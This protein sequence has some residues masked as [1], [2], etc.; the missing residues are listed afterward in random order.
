MASAIPQLSSKLR[1]LVFCLFVVS[2]GVCCAAENSVPNSIKYSTDYNWSINPKDDLT[3]PGP[4]T[5]N[6]P[7]CP[8]G[9]M[10]NEPEYWIYVSGGGNGEA[11]KVTGGT[12]AGNAAPGT[13]QFATANSHAA[14]YTVGSASSGLQE[15]LIAAR[16]APRDFPNT[17]PSGRV[18]V[19]PGEFDA[20]AR[21]SIR[22]SNIEVDFSGSIIDCWMDDTCIF[23]GDPVHSGKYLDISVVGP[24]GRPM[25]KGGQH[26]FLEVNAMKTRVFNVSLRL[27]AKG[28]SF[29]SYVQVDDDQ[30][31]L[32][33]GLDTSLGQTYGTDG[34]LCNATICNPAVYAPGGKTWAVG[35]LKHLNMSLGCDSNG[36]DWESG[37]SLRVSDS[38]IQGYPQYA[39]RAG[40][41]HGGYQGLVTENVYGEIGNCH[42]PAG[43]IGEAGIIAQGGPVVIHGSLVL[44][45]AS[46]LF[47]DTGKTEYRYYI[48]ARSATFGS[49]NLLY[50][51]KARTNGSGSITVTTPDI[52]GATSFDLLRVN[53][54]AAGDP[55]LQTPNGTGNYAVARGVLRNSACDAG[56]CT[57]TDTQAPLSS[58]AVT[59]PTYFPLLK[60][61]PGDVYLG[62]W[63]GH[64]KRLRFPGFGFD[65][66]W[67]AWRYSERF[68]TAC[69]LGYLLLLRRR[70]R[71]D[72]ADRCVSGGDLLRQSTGNHAAREAVG[73]RRPEYQSKRENK[74]WNA[75]NRTEPYHHAFRFELR[76]NRG[77]GEQPSQQRQQ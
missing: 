31:F 77:H 65:Q 63:V 1:T 20:Y 6:L 66:R 61:W 18:I 72:S 51:G 53:Y 62:V 15:A 12:C 48:V 37:N 2:A 70:Y 38:V 34:V 33:D 46:P 29:S 9:V 3:Q 4:K 40:V 8:A 59:R 36:I 58:Y 22:A 16:F 35:W 60:F 17:F 47:A 76:Q 42:N 64:G 55:R 50:A 13:L 45:G 21:V 5:V 27:G 25:V 75:G 49:S 74:L 26:P 24:S 54:V 19:P 69:S 30:A 7:A 67:H 57:F 39:I 56:I 28:G 44:P 68:G 43:K 32:L 52:P 11:A 23:A 14:G 41:A 10:G 71:M 73:R